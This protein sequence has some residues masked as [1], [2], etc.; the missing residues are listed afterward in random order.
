MPEAM[1]DEV[2]DDVR[3]ERERLPVDCIACGH[4]FAAAK[5]IA[6]DMGHNHGHGACP[7]CKTFLHLMLNED[8]VSMSS[9][10]WSDY[11]AAEK[12]AKQ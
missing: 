12:A 7:S 5:S 3:P 9:E 8:G 10:R 2:T 11:L 1:E 6:M 4:G